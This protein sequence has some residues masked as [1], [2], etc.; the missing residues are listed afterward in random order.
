ME[1][2][3][4]CAGIAHS[5][6]KSAKAKVDS[7]T[8]VA[9]LSRIEQAK[10]LI[11]KE[12]ASVADGIKAVEQYKNNLVNTITNQ[13]NDL[14]RIMNASKETLQMV[15]GILIGK[16]VEVEAEVEPD[17][18]SLE[19]VVPGKKRAKKNEAKGK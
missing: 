5:V 1:F 10:F 7:E 19:T 6:Y 14:K 2:I 4:T 16:E 12:L 8:S 18:S 11:N 17:S 13:H 3:E 15:I 9:L